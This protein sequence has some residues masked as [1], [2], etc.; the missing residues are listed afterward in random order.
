MPHDDLTPEEEQVRRLLADARHTEPMPDDVAAR[1]DEVLADLQERSPRTR[2]GRSDRRRARRG[3]APPPGPQLGC[4]PPRRSSSSASAS[5]RSTC[6]AME[7]RRLRR[8]RAATPL[9]AGGDSRCRGGTCRGR[10]ADAGRRQAAGRRVRLDAPT[11]FG[12]QVRR[13]SGPRRDAAKVDVPLASARG[14]SATPRTWRRRT[15]SA[16]TPAGWAGPAG[17]RCGTTASAAGWCSA[18]PRA[19]TQ[20]VDL[21]LCGQDDADPVDHAAG[22]AEPAPPRTGKIPHLRSVVLVVRPRP[23]SRR[24]RLHV[25]HPPRRPERHRHRLRP[26]RLHRRALHRPGQPARRSCS[27]AR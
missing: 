3:P 20:V 2:S 14:S 6:P 18:R 15:P 5:T 13:T 10:R 12:Q 23:P 11:E 26:V 7:R 21:Y 25:R 8:R 17:R 9:A 1:L 16:A 4:S 27:R 22:V 24:A 19:T